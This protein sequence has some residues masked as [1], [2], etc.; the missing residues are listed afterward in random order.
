LPII[1]AGWNVNPAKPRGMGPN[2]RAPAQ[3]RR[4]ADLVEDLLF[5]Q[6][7]NAWEDE[8][9]Q[10]L[11]YLAYG[12]HVSALNWELRDG[13]AVLYELRHIHP[14]EILQTYPSWVFDARGR[15][16]GVYQTGLTDQ[17]T[18]RAFIPA[19]SM[20]YL[21]QDGEY[22]RMEGRSLL[23]ACYKPWYATEQLYRFGLIGAERASV[24]VPLGWHPPGAT[25]EQI[26]AFQ[27]ALEGLATYE[28]A[29]VVMQ[30][31]TEAERYDVKNFQVEVKM[32]VLTPQIQHHNAQAA[33]RFLAT[34]LNLGQEGS[35][36]AYALSADLTDLFAVSLQAVA[37]YV[38]ARINRT[39]IPKLVE[40]NRGPRKQYPRIS[41]SISRTT[42]AAMASLITSAAKGGL[43]TLSDGDEDAFRE[44]AELPPR[45]EA[46]AKP[47]A[48]GEG[49]EPGTEPAGDEEPGTTDP[50]G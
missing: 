20:L 19:D 24:G 9:R 41:A 36:G 2:E 44:Y 6:L 38:A 32:D 31:G 10:L 37:D 50:A 40:Y 33:K 23:R 14:G 25:P 47:T 29:A 1:A 48:P 42:A 35:G 11:G 7:G 39:L 12:F 26:Q 5:Q 45:A 4:D 46:R 28:K 17:G 13:L 15:L 21:A 34:F 18:Q 43:L 30:G 3:A 22:G 16:A 8:V 49:T 27:D